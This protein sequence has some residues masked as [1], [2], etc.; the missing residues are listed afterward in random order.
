MVAQTCGPSS[1]RDTHHVAGQQ[2]EGRETQR[3]FKTPR[4]KSTR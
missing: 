3:L 2:E 4:R 1:Q